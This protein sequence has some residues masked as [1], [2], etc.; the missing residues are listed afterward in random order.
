MKYTH[1]A[2]AR[3]FSALLDAYCNRNNDLA[4]P[5]GIGNPSVS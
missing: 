5:S 2:M 3:N 4:V 1:E